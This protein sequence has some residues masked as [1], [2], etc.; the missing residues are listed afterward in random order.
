MITAGV[1]GIAGLGED[2]A[3]VLGDHLVDGEVGRSPATVLDTTIEPIDRAI[4]AARFG[5]IG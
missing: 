1:E 4:G 3:K 5:G 2:V